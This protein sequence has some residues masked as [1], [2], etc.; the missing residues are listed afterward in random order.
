VR[1]HFDGQIGTQ[2]RNNELFVD[3]FL[4]QLGIPGFGD[5]VGRALHQQV[6]MYTTLG[7]SSLWCQCTSDW[8]G[9]GPHAG[10]Q[11]TL[12][13]SHVREEA[14]GVEAELDYAIT[15]YRNSDTDKGVENLLEDAIKQHQEMKKH[16]DQWDYKA[17]L[18]SALQALSLVDQALTL[19]G[20]PDRIHDPITEFGLAP[21]E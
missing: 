20:E 16:Y 18:Y 10:M 1:W 5:H 12:L 13:R 7:V 9:V 6:N 3:G 21:F 4:A 15:L 2:A 8:N 17:A 14:W 19:M 11:A